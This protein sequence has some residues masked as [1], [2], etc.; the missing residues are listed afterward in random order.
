LG[1][2][3]KRFNRDVVDAW[4]SMWNSYDL[5]MV[6]KLF[7]NDS[8]VSY[9]SSEKQGLI[10][11]IE[12]LRRHHEGFG[13]V[14]GGKD[15]PNKLWIEDVEIEIFNQAVVVAATW[16]FKRGG[17]DMAQRGPVTLFYVQIGDEWRI[18]HANFSN[19]R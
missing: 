14:R 12:A 1:E 16:C 3:K 6:D 7:L 18:A 10:K 9:F 17:S 13:F 19:Y 2:S 4:V 11:G 15:Q 5:S 8:R